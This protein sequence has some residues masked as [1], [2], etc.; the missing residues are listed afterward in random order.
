MSSGA[1][2]HAWA[3]QQVGSAD[4][5]DPRR[6]RRLV[7]SAARIA[8]HPEK[9]F[10]QIFDWDDLRAF[11]RLC[12]GDQDRYTTHFIYSPPWVRSADRLENSP[13][14]LERTTPLRRAL[15][16]EFARPDAPY[17]ANYEPLPFVEAGNSVSH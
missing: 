9:M 14:F 7:Q 15:M 10:N 11:Y 12:N 8:A 3:E 17:G 5:G 2:L 16:G 4:L 1:D 13:E 6:T